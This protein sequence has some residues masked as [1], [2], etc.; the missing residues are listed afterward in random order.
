MPTNPLVGPRQIR[1][2]DG[3]TLQAGERAFNYYD[4]EVG[5]IVPGTVDADG[6]FTFRHDDGTSKCLNGERIC[7]LAYAGRRGWIS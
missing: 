4:H 3:L 2:E 1:T 7:S 5:E 6:W